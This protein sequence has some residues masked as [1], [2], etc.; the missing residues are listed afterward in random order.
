FVDTSKKLNWKDRP[1]FTALGITTIA[2]IL[3]TTAWG[4]YIN[5]DTSL[6]TLARLF[7]DPQVYFMSM[8]GVTVI[9]FILTYA[10]LKYLKNKERVRRAVAPSSPLLTKR[11]V[12]ILFLV[13]MGAQLALNFFAWTAALSNPNALTL[14][15]VGA[16]L[17]TFGVIAH[18]YRYSQ[19]LPF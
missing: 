8:L 5:P 10:F 6:P 11:W 16:V 3:I 12:F 2:Q 1:F 15:D 17:I 14:F 9:S 13:L 7:V 4:F 19:S 18:L